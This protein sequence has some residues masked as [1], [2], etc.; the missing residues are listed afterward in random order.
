MSNILEIIKMCDFLSPNVELFIQ[1]NTRIK[2]RVGGL[3]CCLLLLLAIVAFFFFFSKVVDY[4]DYTVSMNRVYEKYQNYTINTSETVMAFKLLD[5][6]GF[7]VDDTSYTAY[8]AYIEFQYI[9][10]E[11]GIDRQKIVVTPLKASKCGENFKLNSTEFKT[12]YGD[13]DMSKFYCLSLG[14]EILI[15]NPFGTSY[16]FSFIN[17][18]F[19]H[20]FH[21]KDC[22]NA[23]QIDKEL[24][25]Y[26]GIL[27]TTQNFVDN[28]NYTT[29][30]R[31][32][33]SVISEIGSAGFFKKVDVRV[34][35]IFHNSDVGLLL[36][37]KRQV[38]KTDLQDIK[39]D[40]DFRKTFF[41][42]PNL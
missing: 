39:T 26:Y 15:L 42:G 7:D 22:K 21:R 12:I 3:L 10:D 36:E 35:S 33:M 11:K 29:P 2:T 41:M 40:I 28:T 6:N 23:T 17:F 1:G 34:K 31:P 4:A 38:L 14:Q 24:E 8:A 9:K 27:V 37:D 5:G 32:Y 13:A 25:V 16:N 18:N 20:C 30:L 19:N